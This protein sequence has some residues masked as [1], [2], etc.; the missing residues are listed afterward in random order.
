FVLMA[1]WLAAVPL[2]G[3]G[4]QTNILVEPGLIHI[5]QK[6]VATFPEG[7]KAPSGP[8]LERSFESQSNPSEWT[9]RLKQRGIVDAWGVELNGRAIARLNIAGGE[10]VAHFAI[11]PGTLVD[12][13]N[14][15][16]IIPRGHTNDI[17]V[18]ALE[19]IP[20]RMRDL[21][22]LAHV[23][24][25]VTDAGGRAV[26]PARVTV[27]DAEN[28][29]AELYNVKP[30]TAAWRKGI[31]YTG[32]M[33]IEFDLPQGDWVVTA[34]RGTE[35]SRKQ[36]KLR[37]FIGQKASLTLPLSQEVDTPGFVA[38]DTHLHTYTF[39]NH[40]DASVDERVVTLAGEGVEL[41]IATDHNHFTD[42]KPQQ[43]ALGVSQ[44][45]TGVIGNEVT[46]GNGHFNAFPFTHDSQKPNHKETNWVKLVADI[47]NKGAQY[48]ILNHPRWP[49]ITNSPL[50]IWGLNR[51]DGTRTNAVEF[52]MDA[53]ELQNS[54]Y[55]VP[56]KDPTFVLR[57][58]FALL[59][60]GEK[61]WAVGASDSHTISEP[62]GQGR[63]YVASDAE[64]PA[65]IDV[66]AAIKSMRAGNISVSYGIFG[67]ATVNGAHMGQMTKP[68]GGAL[69]VNFH[70][71]CPTWIKA[72]KAV[73]YLNGV[74]VAEQEITMPPDRRFATNMIFEIPAPRHD[75]HLVCVAFG[76]GVKDPSWKTMADF[77]LAVTNPVFVDGDNDGKYSSPRDTALAILDKTSSLIIAAI[78]KALAS[79]DSA[80]G[81]QLL[82]ESKLRI[83]AADLGRFDEFLTSLA[84]TNSA[85]E[86]YRSQK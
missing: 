82:S 33:P 16:A 36:M 81:A 83:P 46:T 51:A 66:D 38:A 25:H 63:T 37:V 17:L 55:P 72:K 62:P 61:L 45:F 47:R 35:W 86:F 58:W 21:L 28:K 12:G 42:Y 74:Q 75:A 29:L 6:S 44:Y 19:V 7:A 32:G 27:V 67:H 20:Q 11:P 4:Q 80:I 43:A 70:V 73:V 22:R 85:Y 40:G 77:T 39:S 13:T 18:S 8:R 53:I 84:K 50:S 14:T 26:A 52:K 2:N 1:G 49:A 54:S 56:P 68:T 60:R 71:A 76:D 79:V 57:D 65:S 5:G 30:D 78:E 3:F 34:T 31:V 15:L 48:V 23:T 24:I 59:N 64:D 10:R 9:L 41:A 69:K